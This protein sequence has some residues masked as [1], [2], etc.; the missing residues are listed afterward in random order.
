MAVGAGPS[1]GACKSP[2]ISTPS[3]PMNVSVSFAQHLIEEMCIRG[4]EI[5]TS[6]L[7]NIPLPSHAALRAPLWAFKEEREQRGRGRCMS[8]CL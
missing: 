1:L 7:R 2:C 6:S 4:G 5:P 8:C 3:L